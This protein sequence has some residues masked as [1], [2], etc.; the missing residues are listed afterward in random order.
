M[1]FDKFAPGGGRLALSRRM[2]NKV[3]TLFGTDITRRFGD[4]VAQSDGVTIHDEPSLLR[5][6]YRVILLR[7]PADLQD[8]GAEP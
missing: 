1:V 2:L 4:I 5:G 7:K 8:K 3:T 6:A